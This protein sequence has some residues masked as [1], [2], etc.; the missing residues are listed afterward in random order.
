MYTW[1]HNIA[2]SHEWQHTWICYILSDM[3]HLSLI[4]DMFSTSNRSP[5][6]NWCDLSMLTSSGKVSWFFCYAIKGANISIFILW[7]L[8]RYEISGA[9]LDIFQLSSKSCINLDRN[10]YYCVSIWVRPE[11][12]ENVIGIF[13]LDF[14]HGQPNNLI[15]LCKLS[16]L[17]TNYCHYS[18]EIDCSHRQIFLPWQAVAKDQI[19]KLFN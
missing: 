17:I 8:H 1:G 13:D 14:W 19:A 10:Q 4:L 3:A 16:L 18:L 6:L 7:I 9:W 12:I 5:L 11:N 15:Q 2:S